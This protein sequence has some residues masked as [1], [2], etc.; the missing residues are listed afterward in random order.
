MNLTKMM[1]NINKNKLKAKYLV[2]VNT[3][4]KTSE[5]FLYDFYLALCEKGWETLDAGQ[6]L[7]KLEWAGLNSNI[8]GMTKE[9][10][11]IE[12]ENEGWIKIY[13]NRGSTYYQLID[14]P[15]V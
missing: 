10:S 3:P 14:H 1:N 4:T 9:E 5:D 6:T 7:K 2:G 13:E 12:L 15:W 11:L 8:T